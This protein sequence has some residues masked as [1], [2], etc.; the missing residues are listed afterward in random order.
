MNRKKNNLID[1]WNFL[2]NPEIQDK[3]L[4]KISVDQSKNYQENW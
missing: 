4:K 2:I 3:A 1:M